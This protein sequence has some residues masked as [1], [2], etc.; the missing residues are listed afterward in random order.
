MW[1]CFCLISEHAV[2]YTSAA[3]W[4]QPLNTPFAVYQ[5]PIP[6]IPKSPIH[7]YPLKS[8]SSSSSASNHALHRGKH[9]LHRCR[10][11]QNQLCNQ[12]FLQNLRTWLHQGPSYHRSLQHFLFSV[13][14]HFTLPF[15][16]FDSDGSDMDDLMMGRIGRN[17]RFMG[18][19]NQRAHG[20]RCSQ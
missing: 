3:W 4:R 12:N 19:P 14:S 18:P 10:G 9:Q 11:R 1:Q 15:L 16:V 7:H 13:F 6:K 8:S 5:N 2:Q 17:P 20:D